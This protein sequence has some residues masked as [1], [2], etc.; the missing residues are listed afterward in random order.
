MKDYKSSDFKA[1]NLFVTF[2]QYPYYLRKFIHK[3][4][5]ELEIMFDKDHE[6]VSERNACTHYIKTQMMFDTVSPMI[7]PISIDGIAHIAIIMPKFD[8]SRITYIY[9]K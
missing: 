9:Q 5:N 6:P 8:E 1:T 3:S 2:E 7:V 4:G